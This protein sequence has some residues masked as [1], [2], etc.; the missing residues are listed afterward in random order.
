MSLAQDIQA[1]RERVLA[2]LNVAHD[3]YEDTKTAWR[4][5]RDVVATGK[6]ITTTNAVTGTVTTEAELVAKSIGY[7]KQQLAEAT[8]QQFLSIFEIFF[9]DLL[10]LWLT[11]YPQNL[12]GKKVEFKAVLE[13]ADKDAIVLLVVNKEL[14][15]VLYERPAG[16]FAY[17]EERAKLGCPTADEICRVAEAK[18]TRDVLTHN[19]GVATK[20][21][22]AKAKPL[23]RYA[24]GELIE[25]GEAYHRATWVLLCKVVAD[26]TDAAGAKAA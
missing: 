7:V 17:F 24:D 23:A 26:V 16:W 8:F 15:E 1:L 2:D 12:G 10:R 14:N 21:Y 18:A 11:A 19:R 20:S 4:I 9:F 6:K 5:V 25:V 22:E 13:A 3:Y